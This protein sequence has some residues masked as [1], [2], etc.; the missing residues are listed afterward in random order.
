MCQRRSMSVR[1]KTHSGNAPMTP[2][3]VPIPRSVNPALYFACDLRAELFL[4]D[5]KIVLCLQVH[6]EIRA[7]AEEAR[8]AQRG[9][10]CYAAFEVKNVGYASGRNPNRQ[11]ETVGGKPARGQLPLQDSAGMDR[12][13]IDAL[14]NVQLS[15]PVSV[16][17][18]RGRGQRLP[19]SRREKGQGLGAI[20]AEAVVDFHVFRLQLDPRGFRLQQQQGREI[21]VHVAVAH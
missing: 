4:G 14:G 19:F 10:G 21:H 5:P 1:I 7:V 18:G 9:I 15:S 20:L 17:T 11:R 13:Y 16:D 2:D 8:K 12:Y 3:A 6:P